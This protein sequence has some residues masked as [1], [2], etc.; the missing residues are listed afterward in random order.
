MP[1]DRHAPRI[2]L[3]AAPDAGANDSGNDPSTPRGEC[4][5]VI[6][7]SQQTDHS[8]RG[9]IVVSEDVQPPCHT[10]SFELRGTMQRENA[11]YGNFWVVSVTSD[12]EPLLGCSFV[13]EALG[14]YHPQFRGSGTIN[15]G[16][17]SLGFV[18]VY[19]CPSGLWK[20]SARAYW[21]GR[22]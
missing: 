15:T 18:G 4:S 5:G 21:G 11:G 6:E 3:W 14:D 20:I 2:C 17:L 7:I 10:A 19:Q 22:P 1:V 8:I 16:H 12:I 9:A 13:S